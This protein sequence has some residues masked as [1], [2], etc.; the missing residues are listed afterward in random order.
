MAETT[1]EKFARMSGKAT[2]KALDAL[3][4]HGVDLRVSE[5]IS[6]VPRR[7]PP[8]EKPKSDE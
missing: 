4:R 8:A 5:P 2:S 6:R 3:G 1:L 7:A